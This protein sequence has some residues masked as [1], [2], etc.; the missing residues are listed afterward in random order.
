[1]G[2]VGEVASGIIEEYSQV[3]EILKLQGLGGRMLDGQ[4]VDLTSF[5]GRI[6]SFCADLFS[7]ALPENARRVR[8]IH[9]YVETFQQPLQ[10]LFQATWRRPSFSDDFFQGTKKLLHVRAKMQITGWEESILASEDQ[11]VVSQYKAFSKSLDLLQTFAKLHVREW[12]NSA[13][14]SLPKAKKQEIAR[15]FEANQEQLKFAGYSDG[16]AY[17]AEEIPAG[18]ILL[19]NHLACVAQRHLKG[20]TT[21]TMQKMAIIKGKIHEWATGLPYTHAMICLGGGK[22]VHME[23]ANESSEE[24]VQACCSGE[25]QWEDYTDAK[26]QEQGKAPKIFYE[27]D[28]VEPNAEEFAKVVSHDPIHSVQQ[29][30][31]VTQRFFTDQKP[32]SWRHCLEEA[33]KAKPIKVRVQDLCMTVYRPQRPAHYNPRVVF[34]QMHVR[35][36]GLSCTGLISSSLAKFG[37]DINP[38]KKV[39]KLSP[40]DFALSKYYTVLY[41]SNQ[42]KIYKLKFIKK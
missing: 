40:A 2:A 19:H 13:R 35:G 37:V 38:A 14:S 29:A 30:Q 20:Q 24:K 3:D 10:D 22:F 15:W 33:H 42:E 12:L 4:A 26:R 39:H 28:I 36:E 16:I 31:K 21:S 25:L 41:S 18:S 34:D 11:D 9:E 6:Y 17:A 7:G 1:M 27:C 5:S 32:G 23:K 8:D